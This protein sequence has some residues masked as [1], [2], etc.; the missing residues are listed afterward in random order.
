MNCPDRE[1]LSAYF[2]GEAP[3]IGE[4]VTACGHCRA[5]LDDLT[6]I[7]AAVVSARP[8]LG[9]A[10]PIRE[11]RRRSTPRLVFALLLVIL[12]VVPAL[13]LLR[14]REPIGGAFGNYDAGGRAVI[15]VKG[16]E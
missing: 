4:H 9:R 11:R 12:L 5:F 10:V 3:E 15:Y 6:A 8:E 7:R 14:H 2:D 13:L 16:R 1:T